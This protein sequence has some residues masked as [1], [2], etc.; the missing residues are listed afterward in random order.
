MSKK[1]RKSIKHPADDLFYKASKKQADLI[2]GYLQL[3]IKEKPR[4]MPYFLY[5]YIIRKVLSVSM[6]R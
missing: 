5:D 4:F 2:D 6:F 3:H 1:I